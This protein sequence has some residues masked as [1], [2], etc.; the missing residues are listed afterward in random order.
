MVF[1]RFLCTKSQK[2]DIIDCIIQKN[3][4]TSNISLVFSVYIVEVKLPE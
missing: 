3:K 2:Y 1:A 4:K